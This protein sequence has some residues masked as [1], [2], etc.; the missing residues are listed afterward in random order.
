MNQTTSQDFASECF[1]L[2]SLVESQ[3]KKWRILLKKKREIEKDYKHKLSRLSL[4]INKK[5]NRNF[6][7]KFY[8]K[9]IRLAF[10]NY[11]S[12]LKDINKTLVSVNIKDLDREANDDFKIVFVERT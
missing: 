9:K 7:H 4:T 6:Q 1:F 11:N 5:E 12:Q 2:R 8:K 3:K 10:E